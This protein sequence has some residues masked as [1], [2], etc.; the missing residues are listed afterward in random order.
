MSK[1]SENIASILI[2][3]EVV[4]GI[5]VGIIYINS[6]GKP[7]LSLQDSILNFYLVLN[8]I[9]LGITVL[10]GTVTS[11]LI[12]R[13]DR[14]LIAIFLSLAAGIGLLIVHA[15]ILPALI[16]SFLSLFGFIIGFNYYLLKD[17]NGNKENAS[18]VK[19]DNNDS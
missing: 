8:S 7:E 13:I 18:I 3:L 14:I 5:T 11:F 4:V 1:K 6:L 2:L 15:V 12:N 17:T 9:F 16:F 10:L 19:I